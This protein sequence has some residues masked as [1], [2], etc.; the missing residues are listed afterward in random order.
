MK[1]PSQNASGIALMVTAALS[2]AIMVALAKELVSTV[3]SGLVAFARFFVQV[4]V[5][6]GLFLVWPVKDS[7]KPHFSFWI[8]G[9]L[10]ATS[11]LLL[12]N[13]LLYMPLVDTTAIY[14]AE[15]LIL[16]LLGALF[17][18]E[19]IGVR[20]I[21]ALLFGFT[22]A[23]IVIQP[24]FEEV[25]LPALFPL[26]AAVSTAICVAITRSRAGKEP[27]RAMQFWIC[28]SGSV[29]L[30]AGIGL[31]KS[32]SIEALRLVAPARGEL[33][34]LVFIGTLATF[35]HMLTIAAIQRTAIGILAPFG[36]FQMV[37][38]AFIGIVYF[39]EWPDPLTW[40]GLAFVVSA[41]L[42]VWYRER[43]ADQKTS[44]RP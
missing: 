14:F 1:E 16:T 3:P 11:S 27:V 8:R 42:Y 21:L 26:G 28:V 37:G 34:G 40:I 17:L 12:F 36:Y 30:A 33:L 44:S 9:A 43:H 31:G 35:V 4:L 24:S 29:V 39:A 7:L 2:S 25:G 22:G 19:R 41:G 10:L 18:G 20:R 6:L 32:S 23:L 38:V 5:L 13:A 15:P